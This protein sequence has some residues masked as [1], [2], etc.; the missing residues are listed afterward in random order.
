MRITG[1]L[2]AHT[3]RN[4]AFSLIDSGGVISTDPSQAN[5]ILIGWPGFL[6]HNWL[7]AFRPRP[8]I[9]LNGVKGETFAVAD[10]PHEAR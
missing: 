4:A 8:P 5:T 3:A 10:R 6:R 1:L 9:R 7:L 2:V